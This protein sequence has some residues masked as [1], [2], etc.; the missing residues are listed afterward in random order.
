MTDKRVV[1]HRNGDP[2][3]NSLDNLA[4][5]DADDIAN[6]RAIDA[7]CAARQAEADYE[8]DIA[9]WWDEQ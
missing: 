3:D 1:H 2:R 7:E 9:Y 5:R 4:L 8:R 6:Q